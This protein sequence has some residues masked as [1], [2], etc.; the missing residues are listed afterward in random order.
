MSTIHEK[1]CKNKRM[2]KFTNQEEQEKAKVF[3]TIC[4]GCGA[5]SARG[6][7]PKLNQIPLRWMR[8][9][10]LRRAHNLRNKIQNKIIKWNAESE[11]WMDGNAKDNNNV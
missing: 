5:I 10:I 2:V 8:N 1:G 7:R 4:A 3:V 9:S 11:L 6:L